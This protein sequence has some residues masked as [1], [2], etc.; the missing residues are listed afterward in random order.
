MSDGKKHSSLLSI[1]VV[2]SLMIQDIVDIIRPSMLKGRLHSV[3]FVLGDAISVAKKLKR[4][5]K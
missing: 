4:F 1:M 5:N 3:R 2:K